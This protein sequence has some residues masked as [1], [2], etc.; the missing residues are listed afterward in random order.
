MLAEDSLIYQ[1]RPSCLAR[2][3]RRYLLLTLADVGM[4]AEA[5]PTVLDELT[6]ALEP[7]TLAAAARAAGTVSRG[8]DQVVPFLKRALARRGL[9]TG[10][11]LE[12]IE[13]R[14]GPATE[15]NTSPY[16]E[17]VRALARLG[18]AAKAALPELRERARDAVR[19][20]PYFPAYQQEA[21]RVAETLS[22]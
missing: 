3:V 15:P 4:P 19:Q 8:Q 7:A 13:S 9:E 10:V 2:A 22:Q 21:A 17:I 18:P 6:N 1:G 20:S 14:S 11:R 5:I 16:L 12:T